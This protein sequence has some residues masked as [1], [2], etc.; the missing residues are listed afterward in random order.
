MYRRSYQNLVR[1][2]NVSYNISAP[3]ALLLLSL[4]SLS[5]SCQHAIFLLCLTSPERYHCASLEN[6][7]LR[8]A[9]SVSAPFWLVATASV[10]ADCSEIDQERPRHA[11]TKRSIVR[12]CR[13]TASNVGAGLQTA[14]ASW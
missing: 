6:D 3:L 12:A 7:N 14:L 11:V 13:A 10:L 1:R 4:Q 8:T 5:F 9:N 2:S